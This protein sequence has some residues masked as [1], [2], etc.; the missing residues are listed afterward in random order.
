MTKRKT[1]IITG[2]IA[3][4]VGGIIG[5][6]L[7]FYF[8]LY[9]MKE[10]IELMTHMEPE[11]KYAE[12]SVFHTERAY[13]AYRHE[14]P[15]IGIWA[16]EGTIKEYNEILSKQENFGF[17]YDDRSVPTDLM[18]FHARLAKLYAKINDTEKNQYHLEQSMHYAKQAYPDGKIKNLDKVM[19]IIDRIDSTAKSENNET[20]LTRH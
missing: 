3:L 19:E 8:G 17:V 6:I 2:S 13:G 12:C 4:I 1:I 14:D 18:L 10:A 15:T 11:M 20:N 16:I 5:S 9:H 7:N